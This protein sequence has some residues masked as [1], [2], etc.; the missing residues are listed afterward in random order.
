MKVEIFSSGCPLCEKAIQKVGER[1]YD[2]CEVAVLDIHDSGVAD[3]AQALGIKTL[4]A[5]AIDGDL[6]QSGVDVST[7]A[8]TEADMQ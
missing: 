4:P 8:I 6:L 7:L 5:I 3:R 2:S 1:A